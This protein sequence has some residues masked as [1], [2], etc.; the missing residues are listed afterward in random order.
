MSRGTAVAAIACLAAAGLAGCSKGA[1]AG[2]HRPTS[3]GN[4]TLT[5]RNVAGLGPILVNRGWTLYMYPPDHQQKVSC[6]K[7]D[8]CVTA[9][10][11]L[12]VGGGHHVIAG[13]GVSQKLIGTAT[14]DGGQVVTYNG[15]PLYYYI[16]DRAPDV[17]NGQG[18]G[19]NWYVINPDGKATK[20]HFDASSG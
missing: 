12:F 4:V 8:G 11:P 5:V 1:A 10:P 3:A 19:F 16:A 7:A 6:T 13:P 9:W 15:W 2:V 18:Q 14:G 20:R 17:I